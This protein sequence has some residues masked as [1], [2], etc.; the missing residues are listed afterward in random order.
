MNKSDGSKYVTASK[1]ANVN[2][3][4]YTCN[5]SWANL[6]KSWLI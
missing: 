2:F 5:Y 3:P 4:L 1:Q 6:R